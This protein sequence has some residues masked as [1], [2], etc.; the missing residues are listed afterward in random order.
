M[1]AM[2]LPCPYCHRCRKD[3][4][5]GWQYCENCPWH[6]VN[7]SWCKKIEQSSSSIGNSTYIVSV[8]APLQRRQSHVWY[9]LKITCDTLKI[10]QESKKRPSCWKKKRKKEVD[11]AYDNDLKKKWIFFDFQCTHDEM[12][13]YTNPGRKLQQT[14]LSKKMAF[15]HL[16]F[17]GFFQHV[18]NLC[19]VHNVCIKLHSRNR[20]RWI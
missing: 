19:V 13:Q 4:S 7:R 2:K 8:S 10:P 11:E 14:R 12:I 15:C 3:L 9:Y 1:S 16:P 20:D 18:P 5:D 17:Y 6:F